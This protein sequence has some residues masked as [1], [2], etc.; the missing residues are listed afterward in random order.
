MAAQNTPG[1][2]VGEIDGCFVGEIDGCFI[3]REAQS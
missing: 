3:D 1:E 2:R